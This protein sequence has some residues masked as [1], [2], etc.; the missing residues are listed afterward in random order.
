MF[1]IIRIKTERVDQVLT[2]TCLHIK[3]Q[4]LTAVLW[5]W[6]RLEGFVGVVSITFVKLG[7]VRWMWNGFNV[8]NIISIVAAY[9]TNYYWFF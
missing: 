8:W 9:I 5:E 7:T 3:V 6:D 1:W 4:S 2:V